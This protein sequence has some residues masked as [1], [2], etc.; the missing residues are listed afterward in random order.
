VFHD[1]HRR[2][3]AGFSNDEA[4]RLEALL[5]RLHADLA[6]HLTIRAGGSERA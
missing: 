5:E 2:L 6:H 3:V 4:S 1:L